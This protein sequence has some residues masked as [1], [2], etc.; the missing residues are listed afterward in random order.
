MIVNLSLGSLSEGDSFKLLWVVHA[1]AG[2]L[3]V[4][5]R[6]GVLVP[7]DDIAHVGL[8][9]LT[10]NVHKRPAL[11]MPPRLRSTVD[12]RDSEG[13]LFGITL[14]SDFKFFALN[15]HYSSTTSQIHTKRAFRIDHERLYKLFSFCNFKCLRL[16]A[17]PPLANSCTSRCA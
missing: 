5:T 9:R 6:E 4:L 7:R 17:G 16:K 1:G 2:G 12:G 14:V 3:F 15:S 8:S 13:L 11:L 10:Q